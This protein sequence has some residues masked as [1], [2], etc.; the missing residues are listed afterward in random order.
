MIARLE[1]RDGAPTLSTTPTPSWP[2]MRPGSQLGTSP[3]RICRSVPQIVVLVILTMA[4]SVPVMTGS[5]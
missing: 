1:G 4:S 3:L 5:G 2:R